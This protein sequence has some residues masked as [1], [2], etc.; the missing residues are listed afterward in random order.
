M[1][2]EWR[3]CVNFKIFSFLAFLVS[4]LKSHVIKHQACEPNGL[5]SA[6]GQWT[7]PSALSFSFNTCDLDYEYG[8]NRVLLFQILANRDRR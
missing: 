3:L 5:N 4:F 6:F 8:N 1:A 2:V 7:N